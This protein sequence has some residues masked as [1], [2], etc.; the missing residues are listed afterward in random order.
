M[1]KKLDVNGY[2]SQKVFEA[3]SHNSD[4][5]LWKQETTDCKAKCKVPAFLWP[6]LDF[7]HNIY[8]DM[9]YGLINFMLSTAYATKKIIH[10]NR[11][12]GQTILNDITISIYYIHD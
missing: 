2:F 10:E 7:N 1:Y 6:R 9:C 12:K 4:S 5:V 3:R 11:G 8:R